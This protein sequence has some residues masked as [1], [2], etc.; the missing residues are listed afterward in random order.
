[1]NMGLVWVF[2]FFFSF[3]FFPPLQIGILILIH[4]EQK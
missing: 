1:M 3:F 4:F 2:F